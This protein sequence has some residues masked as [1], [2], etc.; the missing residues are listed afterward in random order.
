MTI[1]EFKEANKD[2][3]GLPISVGAAFDAVLDA[4]ELSR[5]EWENVFWSL[6]NESVL[7]NNYNVMG[8]DD[9]QD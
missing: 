5:V 7:I 3:A 2:V 1:K 6:A 4:V 8:E 9:E